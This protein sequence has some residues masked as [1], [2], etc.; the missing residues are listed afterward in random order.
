MVRLDHVRSFKTNIICQIVTFGVAQVSFLIQL[1]TARER[2]FEAFRHLAT[3]VKKKA[4]ED[5][6]RFRAAAAAAAAGLW[7]HHE[8]QTGEKPQVCNHIHSKA[9]D[10]LQVVLEFMSVGLFLWFG[11]P[12]FAGLFDSC[13]SKCAVLT[14]SPGSHIW[15]CLSHP[16]S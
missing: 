14:L 2:Q 10:G 6:V 3:T 13:T 9:F 12:P 15:S 8:R 7:F 16:L 4:A 1:E 11:F 5:E